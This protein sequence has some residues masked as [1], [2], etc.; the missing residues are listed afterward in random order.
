[1]FSKYTRGK[2]VLSKTET[3]VEKEV[4]LN[5]EQ[6][7]Q[8]RMIDDSEKL[9]NDMLE[10]SL[11]RAKDGA[12]KSG[13]IQAY[14]DSGLPVVRDE[15]MKWMKLRIA[16]EDNHEKWMR[17]LEETRQKE[18]REKQAKGMLVDSDG[19]PAENPELLLA[20]AFLEDKKRRDDVR[21]D[22]LQEEPTPKEENSWESI[23]VDVESQESE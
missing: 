14:L 1:M 6:L 19:N 15:L 16:K 18:N 8:S 12:A 21:L 4:Q 20:K 11:K 7:R 10:G 3:A 9:L 17:R 5:L 2:I 13:G 23:L 22:E